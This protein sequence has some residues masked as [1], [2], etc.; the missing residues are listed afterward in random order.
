MTASQ[1]PIVLPNSGTLAGLDLV[2]KTNSACDSL[3]RLFQGPTAP[4]AAGLGTTGL[5]GICWHD[6]N[7]NLLK[8]RNQADTA[9]ITVGAFDEVNGLY[10]AALK[11]DISLRSNAATG[12]WQANEPVGFISSNLTINNTT[13]FANFVATAALTFTL[14][15]SSTLWNGC[16]FSAMAQG[17]AITLTP[18]AGTDVIVNGATVLTAGASLTIAQGSSAFVVTD[19]A[20]HWYVLFMPASGAVVVPVRQSVLSAS[21]DNNVGTPWLTAGT[22]L[23]VNLAATA[24]NVR[25]AFAAGFGAA[26]A[27]DYIGS[28]TADLASAWSGLTAST[29]VFLY[30]T[31]N[32]STGA[33]TYGATTLQ[34]ITQQ[35]GT[36]SVVNGQYTFRT[37][38][39]VMYLGNGTTASPVQALF[40]G[41]A[42]TGASS[43]TSVVNYALLGAYDSGWITG[44]P[45]AGVYTSKSAN[46]GTDSAIASMLA[47]CL[48][49]DGMA[50]PVGTVIV[51]A[52]T[53]NIANN[54][55]APVQPSVTRTTVGVQAGAT[56]TGWAGGYCGNGNNNASMTAASWSYRLIAKRSF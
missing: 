15:Q 45:G 41:E 31:R 12:L 47:K 29:T 5:P 33:L 34:P 19:G 55:V 54:P 52:V 9:W 8:I 14:V 21:G 23:A 20:G 43:V 44:L 38:Q 46:L 11:T 27:V 56:A 48:S 53:T 3:A 7:Y 37:D 18:A 40:V 28:V 49:V 39:M 35:G 30:V 36:T 42:V 22:G 25:L 16:C 10:S 24:V 32:A 4:T 1:N 17:G 2:N 51:P 26:G 6:T 13:H 50:Y